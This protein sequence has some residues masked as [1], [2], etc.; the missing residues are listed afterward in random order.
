MEDTKD[1]SELMQEIEAELMAD[2]QAMN[3][4]E[5]FA[6]ARMTD[7]DRERRQARWD[8]IKGGGHEHEDEDEDEDEIDEDDFDSLDD[9]NGPSDADIEEMEVQ[10]AIDKAEKK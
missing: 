5:K 9:E 2:L 7:A 4:A 1:L 6:E 8:N 3:A 10:K